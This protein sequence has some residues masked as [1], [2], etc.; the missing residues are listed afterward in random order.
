MPT[1]FNRMRDKT[2]RLIVFAKGATK[3][4][5]KDYNALLGQGS[6][7]H[8][9]IEAARISEAITDHV[10]TQWVTRA[11]DAFVNFNGPLFASVATGF[12]RITTRQ[13]WLGVPG[14]CFVAFLGRHPS[15]PNHPHRVLAHVMVSLGNGRAAGS[16][17][18]PIGQPGDWRDIDIG[19]ILSIDDQSGLAYWGTSGF[20]IWVRDLEDQAGGPGCVIS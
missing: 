8:A 3:P 15:Q 4:G 12:T 13:D 10:A 6:C 2:N 7:A 14:G 11:S 9:A 19:G 17:N 20:E 5:S 16:N 18:G 1:I